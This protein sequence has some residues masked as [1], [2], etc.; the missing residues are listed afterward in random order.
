MSLKIVII[1]NTRDSLIER[2]LSIIS[3][4]T[5]ANISE[6][7]FIFANIELSLARELENAKKTSLANNTLLDINLLDLVISPRSILTIE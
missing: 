1:K 4:S 3:L 5:I 2:E 6:N 7:S